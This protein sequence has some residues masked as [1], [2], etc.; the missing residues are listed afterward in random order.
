MSKEV[1]EG[2]A[3]YYSYDEEGRHLIETL[4]YCLQCFLVEECSNDSDRWPKTVKL[5]KYQQPD[6]TD[7]DVEAFAATG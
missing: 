2:K 3:T 1:N 6:V 5:T 7:E 4:D